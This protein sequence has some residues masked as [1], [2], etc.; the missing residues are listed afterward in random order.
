MSMPYTRDTLPL[1]PRLLQAA[2]DTDTELRAVLQDLMERGA[3]LTVGQQALQLSP[4]QMAQAD[5]DQVRAAKLK[6]KAGRMS[7]ILSR[8]RSLSHPWVQPVMLA[9]ADLKAR[10]EAGTSKLTEATKKGDSKVVGIVAPVLLDRHLQA[11]S[12]AVVLVWAG[13][14][15]YL[16]AATDHISAFMD[17]YQAVRKAGIAYAWT[18]TS[19][20]VQTPDGWIWVT[21]IPGAELRPADLGKAG[22][23]QP[24]SSEPVW[25]DCELGTALALLD[26]GQ[27]REVG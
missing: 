9:Y 14:P 21:D 1:W 12:L 24:L 6:P 27:R 23:K 4:G 3:A 19:W 22:V 11:Q 20:P 18:G 17:L 16:K 2:Q 10:C 7:T 25:I 8:A 26:Q 13:Y 5:Y 15:A